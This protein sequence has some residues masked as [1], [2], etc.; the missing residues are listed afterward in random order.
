M[1][2]S[3]ATINT[4]T[5]SDKPLARFFELG[6]RLLLG[7]LFLLSGLYKLS[8]YAATAGYMQSAGV[9]VALLP[10]VI[11]TELGGGLAV[12]LGFKT[13]F[14]AF[15]LAGFTFIAGLIFHNHFAD[16]VQQ[17]QFMKN[18]TIVGGLLV[19]VARGAGALSID[20]W[21]SRRR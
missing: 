21:R 16:P 11:A 5:L 14:G 12:I 6:G 19:V 7:Q 9:P 1:N 15:L 13:R 17:Q 8:S 10:L 4:V 3:T 20:A 2:A 18:I